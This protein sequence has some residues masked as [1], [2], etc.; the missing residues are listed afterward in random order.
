MEIHSS[1]SDAEKPTN[2]ISAT[3][4]IGDSNPEQPSRRGV[5]SDE[6][7]QP[8]TSFPAAEASHNIIIISD[9]VSGATPYRIV[10]S[11]DPFRGFGGYC[12]MYFCRLVAVFSSWSRLAHAP[13][14]AAKD[15][16]LTSP[17]LAALKPW[18]ACSLGTICC[19]VAAAGLIPIFSS[20]SIK[21]FLPL[22]FLL[23]VVLVAVRFGRAAG[24]LGTVAAAFLFA[25]YL[26]EPAGLAV[27]DPVAR[28]HLLWMLIVGIVIS[29]LLARFKAHRMHLPKL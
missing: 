7:F 6:H 21:S 20:S 22:P 28:A 4:S 16:L 26:F 10:A 27:S 19:T 12:F 13:Q 9:E 23:I 11:A 15:R 1:S 5:P 18:G 29:D 2:A 17:R 8:V 14:Q 3:R 25:Y 24:V